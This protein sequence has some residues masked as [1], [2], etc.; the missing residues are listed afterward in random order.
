MQMIRLFNA[1]CKKAKHTPLLLIHLA[2]PLIG[3]AAMVWYDSFSCSAYRVSNVGGYLQLLA[4]AFPFLIGVICSM[5]IEQESQAGKFQVL[6][7][8]SKPKCF[9]LISKFDFLV[10]LG[11]GAALLAVFCYAGGIFA[12]LHKNF[13]SWN[14]YLMVTLILIGSFLF[15]YMFH[16]FLSLRFGKGASIGVGIVELLLAAI[17]NTDLGDKIWVAFPCTWG[18]RFVT[19]FTNFVSNSAL[20]VQKYMMASQTSEELQIGVRVCIVATVLS[21]I[22]TS[23]WF[24]RWEGKKSED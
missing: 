14:F 1:D 15:D 23:F 24:S 12:I 3:A 18:I 4:I 20:S 7:T 19:T 13:F 10:L 21:V 6:F 16:L 9:T 22:I 5:C 11:F 2:V 17:F 8:S